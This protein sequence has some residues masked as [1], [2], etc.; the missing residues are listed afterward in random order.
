[1]LVED[2]DPKSSREWVQHVRIDWRAPAAVQRPLPEAITPRAGIAA[3]WKCRK[4]GANR[5][6]AR[7]ARLAT[8]TSGRV[9]L[10]TNG[11]SR[12]GAAP[13]SACA[14]QRC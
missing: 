10:T 3:P 9:T 5:R 7:P 12:R 13:V 1:M 2:R 14:C 6:P 4:C 11:P 8:P